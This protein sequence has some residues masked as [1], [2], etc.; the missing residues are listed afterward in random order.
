M[1]KCLHCGSEFEAKRATARYCSAK[2][3]VKASRS[4]TDSVTEVSVTPVSVTK[5]LPANFGQPDCQCFHCKQNRASDVTNGRLI[6]NHGDYKSF[7]KLAKNEV[8][9]VSLPGDVDY[10]SPLPLGPDSPACAI[11]ERI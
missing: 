11:V 8:N 3:R 4:V 5:V 1:A 9:R 6:I 7:E 2:C 10:Q